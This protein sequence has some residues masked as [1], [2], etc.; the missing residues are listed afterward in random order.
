MRISVVIP[1]YNNQRWLSRA[2]DSVLAQSRPA[3]EIIVVDDG[4]TDQT[5]EAAASY[6]GKIRY[7]R[8]ENAGPSAARNTGIRAASGKWI[9]FLDADDEWL[10]EHLQNQTELLQNHPHLQWTCANYL[11]CL[12]QSGRQ[13]PA[14]PQ[15]Q[16]GTILNGQSFSPDYLRT[17]RQGLTG[18]TDTMLI[19]RELLEKAGLFRPEQ[20]R[21]NDLDLW[22]RIAYLQPQI[23]YSARPEAIHHLEA[24]EHISIRCHAPSVFG[25]LIRRHLLLSARQ[26]RQQAFRSLAAFL[27]Q[28]W[29]RGML[30][31]PAAA[32]EIRALIEEFSELLPAS[33]RRQYQWL[34]AFPNL[35]ALSCRGISS[36]V[37]RLRLRRRSVRKPTPLLRKAP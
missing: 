10:P 29:M 20:K 35:T 31:D 34:T 15:K 23:G 30:F 5:A 33:V 22:L 2:I 3:D 8:Q 17:Y 9:A 18:H 21:F 7:F 32:P 25:E 37:R 13:A 14:L 6:K 36:V 4:S 28:Q 11:E 27:L 1:A 19:R 16:I 24:G 26:N 12:C